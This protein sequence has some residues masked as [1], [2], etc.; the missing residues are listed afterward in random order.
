MATKHTLGLLPSVISLTLEHL[1]SLPKR[2]SDDFLQTY[3]REQ[4]RFREL[5]A[6]YGQAEM[7]TWDTTK[8]DSSHTSSLAA[9]S[10]HE[11]PDDFTFGTPVLKPRVPQLPTDVLPTHVKASEGFPLEHAN[12]SQA[13]EER[14]FLRSINPKILQPTIAHHNVT[15]RDKNLPDANAS[16]PVKP[17]KR[18]PHGDSDTDE[19]HEN[20]LAERRQRKKTK[21]DI[22]K[23]DLMT[24]TDK[25]QASKKR[26]KQT[27]AHTGFALMHG[28]SA[29]NV[30][31]NRLTVDWIP[32]IPVKA[33]EYSKKGKHLMPRKSLDETQRSSNVDITSFSESKFLSKKKGNTKQ[34]THSEPASACSS[35]EVAP[36]KRFKRTPQKPRKRSEVEAEAPSLSSA[37]CQ[38]A[39]YDPDDSVVWDIE[40]ASNL[41]SSDES[42]S[43]KQGSI[44]VAF[45]QIVNFPQAQAGLELGKDNT[46]KL[47]QEKTVGS[48]LHD[49]PSG[50]SVS[51][52]SLGPSQS[53]SQ[54][55]AKELTTYHSSSYFQVAA[56]PSVEAPLHPTNCPPAKEYFVQPSDLIGISLSHQEA[57]LESPSGLV[58][59]QESAIS[60]REHGA[61]AID[62][63]QDSISDFPNLAAA[64]Q[65]CGLDLEPSYWSEVDWVGYDDRRLTSDIGHLDF[66]SMA[67]DICFD[68]DFGMAGHYSG[69]GDGTHS[70]NGHSASD[71]LWNTS[72]NP[73]GYDIPRCLSP[74]YLEDPYY[75]FIENTVTDSDSVRDTSRPDDLPPLSCEAYNVPESEAYVDLDAMS[76]GGREEQESYLAS[77]V[78][79]AFRED[80]DNIE[81]D[82]DNF[83]Q[84]RALLFGLNPVTG[85][86]SLSNRLGGVEA[87][88]ACL[89]KQ[90]H[91]LPQKL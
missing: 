35:P 20:R 30:G 91:W 38:R 34:T 27:K 64:P 70:L 28:F 55:G 83:Y 59:E 62:M 78:Y 53:A 49:N 13:V 17:R 61:M 31:K 14:N 58:E 33:L 1:F 67:S 24:M 10:V 54:V 72:S 7:K 56:Q 90:N 42:D 73:G 50:H 19:E 69:T 47:I 5:Y 6:F 21:K 46:T 52:L 26:E 88:V 84:G 89:L 2:N 87:E 76:D 65:N 79:P 3:H 60:T 63:S 11:K 44:L 82:N 36:K 32:C 81:A 68:P 51:V 57:G 71:H 40:K 37:K 86:G 85:Y 66:S 39:P 75:P 4:R 23:P 41:P 29:T 45:P 16:I 25:E 80:D 77:S 15:K 8:G 22:I 43:T 12:P 74:S 48:V 9:V 18:P